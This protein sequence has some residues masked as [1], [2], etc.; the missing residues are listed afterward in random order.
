M[1]L[2]ASNN[3]CTHVISEFPFNDIKSGV[4]ASVVET[5]MQTL[6]GL[7]SKKIYLTTIEP[8]TASSDS[9]ATLGN[10]TPFAQESD[11]VAYNTW[12]RG[13]PSGFNGYFD[14]ASAVESSLNS[15]LWKVDGTANKYVGPSDGVHETKAGYILI[16]AAG[17]IP[18]ATFIWP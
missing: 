15:G 4:G 17:V 11:R 16:S 1:R 7:W 10:Q 3:Y 5:R 8:D 14:V 13:T 18:T 6:A 9:W 2:L 12:V